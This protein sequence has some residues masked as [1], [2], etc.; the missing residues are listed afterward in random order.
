MHPQGS[1]QLLP[2]A[3]D[4]LGPSV[5]NGSLWHTMQTQDV[6]NIRSSVLLNPIEG[7]H[8]NEMSR[9]GKL[10]D[11]YPNGVKLVVGERHAHNKIH[12]DVFPFLGRNTQR[13]QQSSRPHMISLDPSTRV[14]FHNIANGLALHTSPPEL[15]LSIMIH[16]CD[17][18]VDGIFGS[19]SFIKYLLAQ[20][21]VLWNH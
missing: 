10:V 15:C 20:S 19:V 9:F 17:A 8:Q 12:T 13:L 2:E 4:E 11:D 18:W 21:M 7:V 5:R 14:A 16:L 6:R 1:L 3:S